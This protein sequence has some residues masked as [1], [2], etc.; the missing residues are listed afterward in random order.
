M[1]YLLNHLF[2]T[3]LPTI[4]QS[5]STHSVHINAHQQ[6]QHHRAASVHEVGCVVICCRSIHN[7]YFAGVPEL[8]LVNDINPYLFSDP[9]SVQLVRDGIE[10]LIQAPDSDNYSD[11]IAKVRFHTQFYCIRVTYM[12]A[13]LHVWYDWFVDSFI[14]ERTWLRRTSKDETN[15]GNMVTTNEII[16]IEPS[17]SRRSVSKRYSFSIFHQTQIYHCHCQRDWTS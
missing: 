3:W 4:H 16:L 11:K 14:N 13:L 5:V 17:Y 1:A 8:S 12:M 15:T 7:K 2:I 6:Q 10:A 9:R